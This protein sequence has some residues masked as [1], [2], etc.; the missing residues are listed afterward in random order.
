MLKNKKVTL[1]LSIAFAIALWAYV[2]GEVNPST[3]KTFINV[4]VELINEEILEEQGLAVA[5]EEDI[6]TEVTVEGN[7]SSVRNLK[8]SKIS[9]TVDVGSCGRGKHTLEVDV[10]VPNDL[11]V[12][13]IKD[14]EVDITVE[15]LITSEVPVKAMLS[16]KL[17]DNEEMGKINISPGTVTVSGA[18]SL[19]EKVSYMSAVIPSSELEYKEKT[20][21]LE[22]VPVNSKGG[23]IGGVR[24]ALDRVSVSASLVYSREVPL[25]VE[26]VGEIPDDYDLD[27][28]VIPDTITIKGAKRDIDKVEEITAEDIDISGVTKTTEIAVRPILPDNI[29]VAD[30]SSN[31]KVRVVIKKTSEKSITLKGSV[32]KLTGLAEGLKGEV[33]TEEIKV[34]VTGS[35]SV[36][37]GM[38]ESDFNVTANLSGLDK[39]MQE[40]SVYVNS[41]RGFK[42]ITWSPKNISVEI[43]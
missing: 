17:A 25:K 37:E 6:V 30:S 8:E 28:I 42:S 27:E 41:S 31:L 5:Q 9:A 7:R 26:T 24:A 19:V 18:E 1:I 21:E 23:E 40:V 2:V 20:F 34:Y 33:K 14:Q 3:T 39:G 13:D 35:R 38:G 10:E 32:V 22:A 12:K 11:K 43:K 16:G 36:T 29:E 4:P 15:D